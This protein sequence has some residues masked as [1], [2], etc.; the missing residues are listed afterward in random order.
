MLLD[1]LRNYTVVLASKSPRRHQ[2]LA[3][4]GIDFEV[5]CAEVDECLSMDNFS[6]AQ[7]VE[8]LSRQKAHAVAEKYDLGKTIIIGGDTL[9]CLDDKIIGKPSNKSEAI[10]I[11]QQLSSKK[12]TVVSGLCILH[13]D[14]VLCN[15]DVTE[16]YFK[17][18]K[19]DEIMYYIDTYHPFD[20]AGAYGIQEWI[21]YHAIERINGSFYNVM[22]LPTHLLWEMLSLTING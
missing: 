1:K 13:K 12:H 14:L 18:L 2:L 10:H 17:L 19:D 6:P 4:L 5:H 21:G 11:L 16:V 8:Y 3:G 20:K 7:L 9:V 22:G 15:H